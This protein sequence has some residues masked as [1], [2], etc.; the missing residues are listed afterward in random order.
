MIV[1]SKKNKII[2][3]ALSSILVI[4]MI[5]VV[6]QF[7]VSNTNLPKEE[8]YITIP[9]GSNYED[10]KKIMAPYIKGMSGFEM[11]ASLRSYNKN[12]KPGRFLITQGMGNYKIV[13]SLRR[14]IP[15]KIAFN[16]QERLEDLCI[17]L[18]SQLEPDTTKLLSV[19]KDSVFL[20]QNNFT[21]ENV[22]AM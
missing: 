11:M 21:K 15:V 13:A 8:L 6:L 5:A 12:V 7:F 19:F 16:N 18:S 9:T 2:V 17:R 10:V 22:F 4:T 14:N 3:G 1:V 20:A